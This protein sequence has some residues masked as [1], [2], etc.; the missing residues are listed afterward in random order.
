MRWTLFI[1]QFFLLFVTSFLEQ[2]PLL[3]ED[4]HIMT[5]LASRPQP[6]RG[7]RTLLRCLPNHFS[8]WHKQPR[9]LCHLL[10]N[11]TG[12]TASVLTLAQ[13]HWWSQ[14][15]LPVQIIRDDIT[16]INKFSISHLVWTNDTQITWFRFRKVTL[17]G[18]VSTL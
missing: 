9:D 13:K 15:L 7:S 2:I 3:L 5:I 17:N 18:V 4:M 11:S 12:D 1:S 16:E 8:G 10:C 14:T 6:R